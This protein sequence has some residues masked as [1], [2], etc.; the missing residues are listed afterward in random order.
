ME[1]KKVYRMKWDYRF[2]FGRYE[3][4]TVKEVYEMGLWGKTYIAWVYY[5]SKDTTFC[6]EIVEVLDLKAYEGDNPYGQWKAEHLTAEEIE[7]YNT[8]TNNRRMAGYMK[9][10][11]FNRIMGNRSRA[12]AAAIDYSNCN[13]EANVWRNQGHTGKH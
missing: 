2:R 12:R 9:H 8:T 11:Q 13:L 4:Q 10:K 5:T 6:D 1:E 7:K 3:A